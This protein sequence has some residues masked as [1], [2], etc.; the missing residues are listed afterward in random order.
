[1]VSTSNKAAKYILGL[2]ASCDD[3]AASILSYEVNEL[4]KFEQVKIVSNIVKNQDVE[5]RIYQ[6]V[7]PE[8]AARS[9]LKNMKMVVD[10]ALSE[11]SIKF[12]DIEAIA[13][14]SGPGL[15][16]GVIMSCMY[17]KALASVLD[18]PFIAIN[19]LEG[20]ALTAKLTDHV[21]FPFLLLL[22]SGGHCQFIAVNE[23][24]NYKLLGQTLDD[25][26]GE[27]FDKVAKMLGLGFPGGP[28]IEKMALRGNNNR[29][30]FPRPLCNKKNMDLSFSGLKT[31]VRLQI[32]QLGKLTKQDECDIAA[33]FQQAVCDVLSLKVRYAIEKYEQLVPNISMKSKVIVMAGGVAANQSIRSAVSMVV[34]KMGFK[35]VA[36]P[37]NLCTDNAAMIAFAG[38]LRLERCIIDE[39]SFRPRAR[40]SLEEITI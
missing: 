21:D 28:I 2:E 20:H 12:T 10:Q 17:G 7:V 14:T 3:T 26:V 24:A 40:W 11:A 9:H 19:H 23:L 25:A 4:G 15:I 36:P 22:I 38:L 6:G 32:E 31:A 27:A 39:L 35:L 5:H 37:V 18:K 16:G 30:D 29:F 34:D 13:A 33:S 8:I 1:M